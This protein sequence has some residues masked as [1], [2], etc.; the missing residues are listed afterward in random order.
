MGLQNTDLIW[1]V[2]QKKRAFE[3]EIEVYH[4]FME[5]Q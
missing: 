1:D 2:S 5:L 3:D 4:I